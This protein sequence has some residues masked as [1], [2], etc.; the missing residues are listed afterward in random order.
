MYKL[1][2]KN[3]FSDVIKMLERY[4]TNT[5]DMTLSAFSDF[6]IDLIKSMERD[7][8]RNFLELFL[9]G[10]VRRMFLSLSHRC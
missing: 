1:G 3:N 10:Q 7:Q 6:V 4:I 2:Q 5:E 9:S 8:R